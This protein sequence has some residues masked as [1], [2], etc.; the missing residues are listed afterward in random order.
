MNPIVQLRQQLGINQEEAAM[1][2]GI[3]RGHLS[4][5]EIGHRAPKSLAVV[6]LFQAQRLLDLLLEPELPVIENPGPPDFAE[7]ELSRLAERK[8]SLK[9]S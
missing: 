9:K 4:K 1:L 2:L 3:T 8:K 5:M 7:V 6:Y